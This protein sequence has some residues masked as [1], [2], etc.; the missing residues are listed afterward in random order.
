MQCKICGATKS[1]SGKEFKTQGQLNLHEYHCRMQ[2]GAG[3]Q[4]K[5]AQQEKSCEHEWRLLTH[6]REQEA[7]A[8]QSGYGEVCVK[9][10]ELR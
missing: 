7:A 3:P 4:T 6:G 9:C 8:M 1:K 2:Q 5:P 10:Q